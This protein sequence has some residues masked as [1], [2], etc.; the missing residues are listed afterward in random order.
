MQEPIS[1]PRFIALVTDSPLEKP[2]VAGWFNCVRQHSPSGMLLNIPTSDDAGMPKTVCLV[3]REDGNQHRYMVPLARDLGESEGHAIV[4]AFQD[5]FPDLDFDIHSSATH[6]VDEEE[7]DAPVTV[8]QDKYLSLCAAWAKRQHETWMQDRLDNGWRYGASFSIKDKTNP[9]MRPWEQLPERY[10]KPDLDEPQA[11]LDLLNDQGYAVITKGELDAMKNLMRISSPLGLRESVQIPGD[12]DADLS[13]AE[14]DATA[15]NLGDGEKRNIASLL[16]TAK[17]LLGLG[18]RAGAA[19]ALAKARAL[20][21]TPIEEDLF[22]RERAVPS[23][24][25][26]RAGMDSDD[27]T[28]ARD[29]DPIHSQAPV[30]RDLL[31]SPVQVNDPNP[32][33][34]PPAPAFGKRTMARPSFAPAPG[35]NPN[36]VAA[37]V[38]PGRATFGKRR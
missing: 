35:V 9:L 27:R 15:S 3:H 26:R 17:T 28:A 24:R 32:V 25:L 8:D 34:A 2:V 11:L 10:R 36:P 38:Q 18:D 33:A 13:T 22:R 7:D 1:I 12:F 37:P 14:H 23:D 30:N 29:W 20:I 19:K 4:G 6:A 16:S 5:L 31:A 21:G